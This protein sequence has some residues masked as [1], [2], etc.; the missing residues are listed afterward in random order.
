MRVK[1]GA[2]LGIVAIEDIINLREISIHHSTNIHLLILVFL[3]RQE[4]SPEDNPIT[5]IIVKIYPSSHKVGVPEFT[6]P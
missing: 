6:M 3:T 2:I 5:Q 1:K 4:T